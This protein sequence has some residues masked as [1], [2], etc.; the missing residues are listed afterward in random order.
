MVAPCGAVSTS[1]A[2][3]A[4]NAAEA[5]SVITSG[6][7]IDAVFTDV[8]M[9]GS[10]DGLQLAAWVRAHHAA[11]PVLLTSGN[12]ESMRAAG[13]LEESRDFLPKPY[14][15]Q[16]LARRIDALF[17]TDADERRRLHG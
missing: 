13:Y 9:P 7:T 10:M 16:E 4:A 11:L 12:R 3:T 17:V 6:E 15:L 5:H 2:L 8:Q 1:S 14:A